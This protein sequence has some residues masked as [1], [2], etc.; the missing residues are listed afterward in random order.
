MLSWRLSYN[1]CTVCAYCVIVSRLMLKVRTLV[2]A[3]RREAWWRRRYD[4]MLGSLTEARWDPTKGDDTLRDTLPPIPTVEAAKDFD[5][6]F[7]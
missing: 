7:E 2:T 5:F 4:Q 6:F 3:G 1:C